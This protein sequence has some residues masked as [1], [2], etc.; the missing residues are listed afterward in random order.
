[1]TGGLGTGPSTAVL[2]SGS[3]TNLQAIIDRVL[4]GALGVRLSAV[5]SDAPSAFGLERARRAGIPTV[6]VNYRDYPDRPA[7]ERA[8]GRALADLDPAIVVLAGFM[9]ILPDGL[10]EAYRGRMLNVHPSLLPKYRGLH[11]YERVLAAGDRWHGTTVHFVVP[12]LDAGPAIIQY[13]VPVR[14]GEDEASL[15]ERVQAGEYLIYPR[16]I[17]WL[18]T[19]R[20]ALRDGAAW[21]DGERL[22]EPVRVEEGAA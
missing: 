15:R 6:T 9:R 11:T 18:A 10:V 16:A 4:Q 17:D 5:L 12:E 7:A 20:L 19:G 2:V 1:V 22:D 3:G 8:L 21:L 14:R 13:R